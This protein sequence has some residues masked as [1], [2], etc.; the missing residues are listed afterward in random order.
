MIYAIDP[1]Y[2]LDNVISQ[3]SSIF[4]QVLNVIMR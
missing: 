3:Y 1:K 4:L 2:K